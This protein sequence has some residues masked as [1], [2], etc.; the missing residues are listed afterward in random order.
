MS[1]GDCK[2]RQPDA[3]PTN[4]TRAK[5][6]AAASLQASPFTVVLA[7]MVRGLDVWV[8]A[9]FGVLALVGLIQELVT[10]RRAPAATT[11]VDAW[12][13]VPWSDTRPLPSILGSRAWGSAGTAR[14]TRSQGPEC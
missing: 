1:L 13:G 3:R 7:A 11:P 10:R 9:L 12:H 2:G 5:R 6:V 4:G 8:L 14:R